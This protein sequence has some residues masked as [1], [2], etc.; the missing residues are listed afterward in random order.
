[1]REIPSLTPLHPQTPPET[2]LETVSDADFLRHKQAIAS[3]AAMT[4]AVILKPAS[5]SHW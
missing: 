2:K 4:A 1:M 3:Q 5:F